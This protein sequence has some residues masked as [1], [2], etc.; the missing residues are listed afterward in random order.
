MV[1]VNIDIYQVRNARVRIIELRNDLKAII[2]DIAKALEAV[3]DPS[4]APAPDSSSSG[5]GALSNVEEDVTKPFARVDGVAPNSPAA[6]AVCSQIRVS[7]VHETK[8][9][10][11]GNAKRGSCC[12]IWT[13]D[14]RV[15]HVF[16]VTNIGGVSG[17]QRKCECRGHSLSA[18]MW[19]FNRI[20]CFPARVADQSP[21][22]RSDNIDKTDSEERLGRPWHARVS[23]YSTLSSSMR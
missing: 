15:V 2:A 3:Y 20:P 11:P 19:E 21:S 9:P 10:L 18:Q 1:N 14:E 23:N 5:A 7:R 13:P 17:S 6:E 4:A 8:A 16:V 12:Q 22:L